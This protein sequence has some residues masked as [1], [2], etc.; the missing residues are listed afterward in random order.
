MHLDY[1]TWHQ[2]ILPGKWPQVS[3]ADL[4]LPAST[5][6]RLGLGAQPQ[7]VGAVLGGEARTSGC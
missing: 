1:H 2:A 3:Q 7:L 6:W 4:E 5:S